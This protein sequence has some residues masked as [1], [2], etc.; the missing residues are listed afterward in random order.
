VDKMG[1]GNLV[2]DLVAEVNDLVKITFVNKT[3]TQKKYDW[4]NFEVAIKKA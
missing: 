2:T 1:Y 4:Y 3:K